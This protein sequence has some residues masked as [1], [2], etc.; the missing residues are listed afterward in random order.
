MRLIVTFSPFAASFFARTWIDFTGDRK[1]KRP[2]EGFP[3]ERH[4]P[5]TIGVRRTGWAALDRDPQQDTVEFLCPHCGRRDQKNARRERT[6]YR[7]TDGF[8]QDLQGEVTQ[9]HSC[10][11]YLRVV[12]I[13]LLH[14]QDETR[15][16]AAVFADEPL[17]V[18][19]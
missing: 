15:R 12:P 5:E 7:F 6:L 13:V 2:S 3:M 9:C 1:L 4:N 8:M 16:F 18:S 19:R 14:D 11:Q 17:S 10:K